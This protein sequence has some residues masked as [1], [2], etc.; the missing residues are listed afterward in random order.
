MKKLIVSLIAIVI[1]TPSLARAESIPE[2]KAQMVSVIEQIIDLEMDFE[3]LGLQLPENAPTIQELNQQ[4]YDL[5]GEYYLL[6]DP[7][8]PG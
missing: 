8:L 5:T 7:Q 1:L 4:H 6:F 2:L 3:E